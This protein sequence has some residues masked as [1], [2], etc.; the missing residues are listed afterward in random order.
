M[1]NALEVEK[2][3]RK[4]TKAEVKELVR[5][6]LTPRDWGDCLH[7]ACLSGDDQMLVINLV[8]LM[9]TRN[10]QRNPMQILVLKNLT[11]KL[12]KETTIIT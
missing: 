9:K 11:S 5:K 2:Q 6:T 12:Q 10:S 8:C 7:Q 4:L 1:S 3:R